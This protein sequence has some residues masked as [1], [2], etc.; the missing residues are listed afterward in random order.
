MLVR[1]GQS[2]ANLAGLVTGTPDDV[3]SEEGRAQALHT[4]AL[5]SHLSLRGDHHFTSQF[6]RAQQTAELVLPEAHFVADPRL[7]ETDAGLVAEL[8]LSQFLA[9]WPDFY[10]S[11][12]NVYPGGESHMD[13]N[14]RV[15]DW[16]SEVKA[17]CSGQVVA[18]THAGPI[19]C[20][21]QSALG[22]PMERF[23]A[24]KALN[25][26]VSV[27]DYLHR[28]D[29]GRVVAFSQLP[30]ATAGALICG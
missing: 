8:P 16:L 6:R 17:G 26:S 10:E 27:I 2:Q 19:C 22:I 13:L 18:V 12:H 30:D 3:L 11:N 20:L 4:A 1:H 7:G 14:R 9:D 23:P 25:A 24:L 15:L 29:S 5:F 28:S 21:L